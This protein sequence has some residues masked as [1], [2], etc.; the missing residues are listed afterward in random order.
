M[1]TKCGKRRCEKEAVNTGRFTDL[2]YTNVDTD[3]PVVLCEEHSKMAK[4]FGATD[5]T[6]IKKWLNS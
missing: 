5:V 4:E 3:Y 1:A 2:L 6:G